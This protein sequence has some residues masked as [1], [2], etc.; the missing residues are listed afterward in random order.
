[1]KYKERAKEK[2]MKINFN[3]FIVPFYVFKELGIV[4]VDEE[5][6]AL[7]YK[8]NQDIKTELSNSQIYNSLNLI[9]KSLKI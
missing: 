8:I 3:N 9:K 4:E 6:V 7:V 5:K 2:T 1:V